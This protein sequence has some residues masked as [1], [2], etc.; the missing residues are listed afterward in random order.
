METK[1]EKQRWD[2]LDMCRDEI[3]DIIGQR[4]LNVAGKEKDKG[5]FSEDMQAPSSG[6]TD[7]GV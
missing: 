7:E 1:L 6:V 5:S 4:M 3:V 2:G